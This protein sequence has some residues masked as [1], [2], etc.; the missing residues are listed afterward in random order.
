MAGITS[1]MQNVASALDVFGQ[2][3]SAEQRN[4][5]NVSTP[6]YAAVRPV[7]TSGG[8]S[9]A[10]RVDLQ[11]TGDAQVDA[12]VNSAMSEAGYASTKSQQ[13]SGLNNLFDITGQSG[14]PAAFSNF[15]SAFAKLSAAPGDPSL[16]GAA[17][18]AAD[19]VAASFNSTATSIDQQT[20]SLQSSLSSA[21]SQINSLA[22]QIA[23]INSRIESGASVNDS[24]ASDQLRQALNSL[25]NL[26]NIQVLPGDN[27]TVNVLAGGA[28]PLVMGDTAFS[29]TADLTAAPG[30]QITSS[31]GGSPSALSGVIGG[32]VDVYNNI[33]TPLAGGPGSPG[34]LSNLAQS[35]ADTVNGILTG[36]VTSS[37]A[38]GVALL[39]YNSGTPN[40][41]AR[42]LG[43]DS[44]VTPDRL[45]V[46][47]AG[48]DP[49][50]NGVA[51][52]LAS[53]PT[54]PPGAGGASALDSYSAIAASIGQAASDAT[55]A[56]TSAE[57]ALTSAQ[58]SQT[59]VEGV[60]LD[61]EAVNVM[62]YQR[63]W[64]ASAKLVS[65][66]DNLNLDAVN[67]VG[68]QYA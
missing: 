57:T 8:T 7:I 20:Q 6:G 46:A 53:V 43:I 41:A 2:A 19:Q 61:S 40:D 25:S 59:T 21:L 12:A 68:Q 30:Q 15:S 47:T 42:T 32:L 66:F 38:P 9:A 27:G 48:V 36:G 34:S 33:L 58:A 44:S 67:L 37:G 54:A 60:S 11:S 64:E 17:I 23:D 16:A 52:L 50:S 65:V 62:A 45:A 14:I 29:L 24:G 22:S 56:Q 49:Q 13:L 63:A 5:S 4:I 26:T 10:D 18:D 3:L 31:G 1:G 55:S 35:F 39:T 28:A 51:N